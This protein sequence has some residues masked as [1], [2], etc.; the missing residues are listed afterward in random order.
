MSVNSPEITD[1]VIARHGIA[2]EEY[3]RIKNILGRE[4][5]FTE[6]GI[7][8]VMWSE[9]CSYKNS[10]NELKKFPTMGPG[11]LVKAGEYVVVAPVTL[12]ADRHLVLRSEQG[13]DQTTIRMSESPLD[14]DRASVVF[15]EEEVSPETVVE[16]FT[17]TGGNGSFTMYVGVCPD[18]FDF[19]P[20]RGRASGDSG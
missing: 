8:S 16:G 18:D 14:P 1:E 3:D 13:A 20:D 7:F 19:A 11:V 2:P 6:L 15:F 5:N 17:I 9:H 4:P 12:P 10:R